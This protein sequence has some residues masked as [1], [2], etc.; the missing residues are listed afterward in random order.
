MQLKGAITPALHSANPCQRPEI[1]LLLAC[2]HAR[3]DAAQLHRIQDL[4]QPSL[5]W[6]Y[7]LERAEHHSLMPLLAWHL[8]NLDTSVIPKEVG[9]QIQSSF[10]ENFQHNMRLLVELLKLVRLFENQGISLLAFKGPV[11]AQSAYGNIALRQ[12]LDLDILVPESH[13]T[14][15]SQLLVACNYQPQ[16]TLTA[17]QQSTY[18]DLRYEHSFWHEEKQ[19]GVDLHWSVLPK[20]YS[21]T[22]DPKLLWKSID[23]IFF[24]EQSI[25]TLSPEYL[26]LFLCAHGAKHNWSK[27]YWIC[28]VAEVLRT[29]KTLDW[30][31]IQALSGQF[32]TQRMLL[33]G[34]Y[35]AHDLLGASLPQTALGQIQCDSTIPSLA[36]EVRQN[37]FQ[38]HSEPS[39]DRKDRIYR[40]TMRSARDRVWYWIDT[41]FTPTPLEWEIV[42]LPKPLF[43]LY[44][45]VR[46]VRL[47]LKYV[48]PRR[49]PGH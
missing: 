31:T 24:A 38:P 11:L 39:L 17:K 34:L 47:A 15:A 8:Q 26:L 19:I 25:P 9:A 20:Y 37:L 10:T 7:L 5:D 6:P 21:F 16:F 4:L 44:Y 22:P 49:S 46:M 29:H 12:F 1:D 48:M 30:Q 13:V 41:V 3:V 32:G 40:Q 45:I 27:L 2:S 14:Q 18:A 36:A 42:A 23:R 35:L 33:L 43:P 28:D